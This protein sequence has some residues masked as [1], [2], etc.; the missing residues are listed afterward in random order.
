MNAKFAKHAVA[1]CMEALAMNMQSQYRDILGPAMRGRQIPAAERFFASPRFLA[2]MLAQTCDRD[3]LDADPDGL[4]PLLPRVLG[5][6]GTVP[7][8]ALAS[9]GQEDSLREFGVFGLLTETRVLVVW[10]LAADDAVARWADGKTYAMEVAYRAE[11]DVSAAPYAPGSAARQAIA[12]INQKGGPSPNALSGIEKASHYDGGWIGP[13][14]IR[15]LQNY[16]PQDRAKFIGG[17]G[18]G[19]C[20]ESGCT[21]STLEKIDEWHAGFFKDLADYILSGPEMKEFLEGL[22]ATGLDRDSD[23]DEFV[24]WSHGFNALWLS[25]RMVDGVIEG[26]VHRQMLGGGE[27]GALKDLFEDGFAEV[28]PDGR[29]NTELARRLD[30]FPGLPSYTCRW[31]EGYREEGMRKLAPRRYQ[32]KP[33]YGHP[34]LW[35]S[36]VLTVMEIGMDCGWDKE[37]SHKI[38]SSLMQVVPCPYG[39]ESETGFHI[40]YL[41]PA[42]AEAFLNSDAPQ[43]C[44]LAEMGLPFPRMRIM[45][46][47][48]LCRFKTDFGYCDAHSVY[49]QRTGDS[50]TLSGICEGPGGTKIFIEQKPWENTI[51]GFVRRGNALQFD[52]N[53]KRAYRELDAHWNAYESEAAFSWLGL[54]DEPGDEERVFWEGVWSVVA[55][56]LLMMTMRPDWTTPEF[57]ERKEKVKH[58]KVIRDAL[59]QP[60]IYGAQYQVQRE[61]SSHADGSGTGTGKRFHW[62]RGHWRN[63]AHGEGWALRRFVWLEPMAVGAQE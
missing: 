31:P 15:I 20:L 14:P 13:R 12:F 6:C 25:I 52:F 56:M 44:T 9:V 10:R 17:T 3:D 54:P 30:Q 48:G 45:L 27:N 2:G 22:V 16:N 26:S 21:I 62:R 7:D 8:V 1:L 33:G 39:D 43:D 24:R 23:S 47:K 28:G 32:A 49:L 36:A 34:L 18:V 61:G 46:P 35:E 63:Q 53:V 41:A 19:F 59:W 51:A 11:L 29:L 4:I 58:G 37:A 57:Q 5:T 60:N 38:N 55:Q 42:L 50:I 40:T